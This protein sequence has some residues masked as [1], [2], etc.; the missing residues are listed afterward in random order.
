MLFC[1]RPWCQRRLGCHKS[2]MHMQKFTSYGVI[3][4]RVPMQ[5]TP[6]A[7]LLF[8]YFHSI[9]H[10]TFD[11]SNRA[12][13]KTRG[14]A[15]RMIFMLSWVSYYVAVACAEVTDNCFAPLYLNCLVVHHILC[16]QSSWGIIFA[17]CGK[18]F[19][20]TRKSRGLLRSGSIKG[21]ILSQTPRKGWVET[22]IRFV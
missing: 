6:L 13:L 1:S 12:E 11:S 7:A 17:M 8:L 19:Y 16:R 22:H 15:D 9:A 21:E 2:L 14:M 3:Q 5:S 10:A 4:S 18:L 20:F